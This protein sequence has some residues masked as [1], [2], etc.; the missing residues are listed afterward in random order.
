MKNLLWLLL[1]IPGLTL[2]QPVTLTGTLEVIH[3]DDFDAGKGIYYHFFKDAKGNRH[4]LVVPEDKALGLSGDK[5]RV[6]GVRHA[7]GGAVPG[8]AADEITSPVIT[9][10]Q[11]KQGT[12]QSV[13]PAPISNSVLVISASYTNLAAG[14]SQ[15]DAVNLYKTVASYYAENSLGTNTL[16]VTTTPILKL[17]IA[18]NNCD[19]NAYGNAASS[20]AQAA[21]FNVSS[22]G[23]V[24]YLMPGQS[25]G[26]SGLGYVGLPH[27]SWIN[28]SGYMSCKAASHELGHNFGNLHA[29]SVSGPG[30]GQSV[31]EYGDPYDVMGSRSCNHFAAMQKANLGFIPVASVK[32]VVAGTNATVVLDPL[33]V[34][35]GKLYAIKIPT[36]NANRTYWVE[37]RQSTGFDGDVPES[38]QVRLSAPFESTAGSDDVQVPNGGIINIATGG[39]YTDMVAGV[40]VT[41]GAPPP[42]PSGDTI[43]VDDAVPAG[44]TSLADGDSWTWVT[45]PTPQCGTKVQQSLLNPG[46]HQ[47]YFQNAS[48]TIT[49]P[50]GGSLFAYVYLDTANAPQ[51]VMLQW[52]DGSWDHR[53][54][55]GANLIPYPNSQ[56][57]VAPESPAHHFVGQLPTAGQWVRL[58]VP[59][60]DIG[61]EGHTVSGMAFTLYSGRAWW[62]CGGYKTP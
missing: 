51:E 36:S 27:K 55:W 26:W 60:K 4:R 19:W 30:P 24:A 18:T 9:K 54:Y 39:S 48:Q 38:V 46:V 58:E 31:N 17:S 22:Y 49:V 45:S 7:L 52:N 47:H 20:A 40:T 1:L 37:Y 32:Q 50:T 11:S 34:A 29:G 16:S 33:E 14:W 15:T 56:P 3:A 8:G 13:A 10:L 61:L 59:A 57:P 41:V 21:G 25:C 28:G 53:A 5:V 35:G 12:L 23:F 2:A 62:D 42:P 44:A 6:K 43:W